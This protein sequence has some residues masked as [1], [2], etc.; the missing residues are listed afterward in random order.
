MTIPKMIDTGT[1][2]KLTTDTPFPCII[3]VNVVNSTITYTSSTDAPARINCG[4]PSSV[5]YPS[6]INFTI[7]GTTTAGETAART[8]P[9]IAAS[10]SESPSKRGARSNIPSN[11][12]LAGTKHIIT[13]GRPIF[14]SPETSSPS[15]AR[16]RI[17]IRA[18]FLSSDEMFRIFGSNKS[19]TYGPSTIPVSNIPRSPGSFNFLQIQ[20]ILIPQSRISAILNNIKIPSYSSFLNQDNKS[21]RINFS[22]KFRFGSECS[23]SLE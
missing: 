10:N 9:K 6:S 13:A 23:N 22:I 14:L 11:S 16:I 2:R 4:I 8:E 7:R 20:L 1:F 19:C 18:I 3:P 5:P 21:L 17:M 15:P 12:K